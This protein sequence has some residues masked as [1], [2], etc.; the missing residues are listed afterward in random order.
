MS[1]FWIAFSMAPSTLRSHGWMTIWCGSGTLMP[2][3]LVERRLGAVVVD[4]DP[5]DERGRGASGADRPKSR[6]MTSTARAILCRPTVIDVVAHARA[7]PPRAGDEGPDRLAERDPGMLSGRF[8]SKTR[9]GQV[10]LHAQAD[11]R[12][13]EDLELVAQQVGVLEPVVALGAGYASSGRRRR[14]RRPWSP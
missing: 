8:R 10:V 7:P 5:L 14:P 1:L 6:S 12:R 9:I 2:G 4:V 13:V 11:R 3:E